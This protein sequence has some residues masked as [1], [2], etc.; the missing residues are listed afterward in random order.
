MA[1]HGARPGACQIL[2]QSGHSVLQHQQFVV[3]QGQAPLTT[4]ILAAV[5]P[6]EQ[7]QML[8]EKLFPL[9]Q[10]I[11]P[12]LAGKITGMLLEID[13]SELLHVLESH[14][15]LRLKVEEAVAMLQAHQAKKQATVKK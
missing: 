13:N 5:T 14:D 4:S 6:S 8:G 11:Y 12:H 10:C 7:K 3:F 15:S 2:G 9:I 1:Q